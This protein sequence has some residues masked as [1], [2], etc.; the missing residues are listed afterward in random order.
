MPQEIPI[1]LNGE[2]MHQGIEILNLHLV[3]ITPPFQ[4]I[5]QSEIAQM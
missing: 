5:L 2:I 1:R 4:M 3:T